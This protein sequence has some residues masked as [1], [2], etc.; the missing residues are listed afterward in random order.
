MFIMSWQK[1]F[2]E[3][4]EEKLIMDNGDDTISVDELYHWFR[5]RLKDEMKNDYVP[6]QCGEQ[7]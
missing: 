6:Y 7:K 3:H 4:G 1:F 2:Q 5:M